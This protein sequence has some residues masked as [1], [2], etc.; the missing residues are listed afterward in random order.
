MKEANFCTSCGNL[1]PS[2]VTENTRSEINRTQSQKSFSDLVASANQGWTGCQFFRDVINY[3]VKYKG[4]EDESHT[5]EYELG[6]P[7]VEI[8]LFGPFVGFSIR[9]S[10]QPD[11]DDS[12][13]M[14]MDTASFK[15]YEFEVFQDDGK[16]LG[17]YCAEGLTNNSPIRARKQ[18]TATCL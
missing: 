17:R 11:Y 5:K 18:F 4:I 15:F 8:R 3:Q 9:V 2:Q 1:D 16:L 12:D 10:F 14:I 7:Q 13:G 6:T